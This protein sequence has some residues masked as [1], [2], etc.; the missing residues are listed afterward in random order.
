MTFSQ[1]YVVLEIFQLS[2]GF[3]SDVPIFV[4]MAKSLSIYRD[5]AA[6][7]IVHDEQEQSKGIAKAYIRDIKSYDKKIVV[8]IDGTHTVHE[9]E[10]PDDP[11]YRG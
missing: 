7:I 6:A 5:A 2:V 10:S 1:R 3:D 8:G 4:E 11:V 9:I